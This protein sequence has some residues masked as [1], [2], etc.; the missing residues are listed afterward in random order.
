MEHGAYACDALWWVELPEPLDASR[1]SVILRVV[2][3]R[4]TDMAKSTCQ[5]QYLELHLRIAALG[6]FL[7]LECDQVKAKAKAKEFYLEYQKKGMMPQK[8]RQRCCLFERIGATK[9]TTMN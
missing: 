3:Q 7:L 9:K 1:F 6:C 8:K 4:T 2:P 5:S